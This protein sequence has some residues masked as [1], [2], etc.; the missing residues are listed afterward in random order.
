MREVRSIW[1]GTQKV[2]KVTKGSKEEDGYRA[3]SFAK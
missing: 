2:A 1:F 3:E